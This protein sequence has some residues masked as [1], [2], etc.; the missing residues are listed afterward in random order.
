M[1]L[2]SN[3]L[4]L[5]TLVQLLVQPVGEDLQKAALA[6]L[7]EIFQKPATF[8]R[9]AASTA[10]HQSSTKNALDGGTSS[11]DYSHVVHPHHR[12]HYDHHHHYDPFDPVA[13]R[14]VAYPNLLDNYTVMILLAMLH[15]GLID[16][17][18]VLGTSPLRSLAAPA[19]DLLA[20]IL[21]L[22]ARLLP[23]RHCA[24]I[25]AL[26]ALVGMTLKVKANHA[27]R[28]LAIRSTRLLSELAHAV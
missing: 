25:L 2:A 5:R 24:H 10:H 20:D 26:P 23:D 9:A 22:S 8:D 28:E 27:Q 14:P 1:L 11:M 4:G 12:Y 18:V 3:P 21:R 15:C 16:A 17:L 19:L 13:S 6:T 7:F